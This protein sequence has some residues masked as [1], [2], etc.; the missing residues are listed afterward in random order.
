MTRIAGVFVLVV[1]LYAWLYFSNPDNFGANVVV[2]LLNRHGFYGLLTL[3]VGVLIITGGIDLSIGSVVALGAVSF[4]VLMRSGVPPV[5][6]AMLVGLGGALIGLL[7]GILCTYGQLQSFLV[8]LCGLFVYRGLARTISGIGEHTAE[9]TVSLYSIKAEQPSAA[10][11]LDALRAGIVGKQANGALDFP[12]EFVLMLGFAAILAVVLH[13]SA[14]GRYWYAVGSNRQAA[15]YS[16]VNADRH[17]IIAF[18][19]SST[20]AALGG[21]ILLLDFAS[22][23]PASAGAE[24]ELLAITGAVIGGCSLRGGEGTIVGIVLGAAIL[25]AINKLNI[26]LGIPNT[27]IPIVVGLTLLAGA[28]LDEILRR[29]G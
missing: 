25:P 11:A 8:T 12:M 20:C 24:F 19:I 18:I 23:D 4:G 14:A 2:D 27:V 22:V 3:G 13:G 17:Q 6:A 10:S 5:L 21:V 16:G 29:R 1:S 26:F 7:H 15:R 9:Q 28:S